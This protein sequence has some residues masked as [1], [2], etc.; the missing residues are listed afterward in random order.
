MTG[1]TDLE[2][3]FD[4]DVTVERTS[5]GAGGREGVAR[6]TVYCDAEAS[7]RVRERVAELEPGVTFETRR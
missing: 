3:E 6:V 5:P 1:E 4:A 2:D 7:D